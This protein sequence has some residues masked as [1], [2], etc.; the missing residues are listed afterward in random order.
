MQCRDIVVKKQLIELGR[1]LKGGGGDASTAV[2][3]SDA[4]S[5]Q[6]MSQ[7]GDGAIANTLEMLDDLPDDRQLA[8]YNHLKGVLSAKGLL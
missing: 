6:G 7:K 1:A 8:A 5:E 3:G 4:E 2:Q